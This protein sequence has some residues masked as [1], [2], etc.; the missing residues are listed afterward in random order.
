MNKKIYLIII[1]G[2][3]IF[4]IF[5]MNLSAW[6]S[7]KN[8]NI[9]EAS[10]DNTI[11]MLNEQNYKDKTGSIEIKENNNEDRDSYKFNNKKEALSEVDEN[12]YNFK[13]ESD[14]IT[15]NNVSREKKN[16]NSFDSINYHNKNKVNKVF[17]SSADEIIK[18]LTTIEKAKVLIVCTKLS[19]EEYKNISEYLSYNNERLGVLKVYDILEKKLDDKS[20]EDLK[21]IFFRYM[22]IEKVKEII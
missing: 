6:D 20:L 3:T 10:G 17:N 1:I 21:K 5:I 7:N 2:Y 19:R 11:N 14:E 12:N 8:I 9:N 4:N 16:K 22:D 18:D 15:N 13:Y